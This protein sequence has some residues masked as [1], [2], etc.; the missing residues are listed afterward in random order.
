MA[1]QHLV[2]QRSRHNNTTL[3]PRPIAQQQPRFSLLYAS[4]AAEPSP[5]ES[6]SISSLLEQNYRQ[7]SLPELVGILKAEHPLCLESDLMKVLH[8]FMDARREAQSLQ[9][10]QQTR[11]FSTS[12]VT[13]PSSDRAP[14]T[15]SGDSA[16]FLDSKWTLEETERLKAYLSKT[17]GRKNWPVCAQM[18]RTKSSSQCKAK[19]NNL[20]IQRSY[21]D[22]FFDGHGFV[23]RLPEW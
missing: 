5:E 19:F 12:A 18:V 3:A 6:M 13:S 14:S 16:T 10:L 15:P 7:A 22:I 4:V 1:R 17:R 2:A 9:R 8:G 21:R 23:E 11:P 20:R